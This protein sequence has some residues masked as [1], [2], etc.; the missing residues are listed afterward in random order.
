MYPD[1]RIAEIRPAGYL[2]EPV[3]VHPFMKEKKTL[4]GH[5]T[6]FLFG[7]E[8]CRINRENDRNKSSYHPWLNA[9]NKI[10]GT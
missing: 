10:P 6:K 2:A 9:L 8:N 5:H 3:S 1:L 7:L 4:F